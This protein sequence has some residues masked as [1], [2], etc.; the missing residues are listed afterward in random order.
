M[1]VGATRLIPLVG[2]KIEGREPIS[3]R[4][5]ASEQRLLHRANAIGRFIRTFFLPLDGAKK[6]SSR[7]LTSAQC[8]WETSKPDLDY[9]KKKEIQN[10]FYRYEQSIVIRCGN[11]KEIKMKCLIIETKGCP[12]TGALNHLIVQANTSTLDNNMP[13]IYPYLDSYMKEKEENPEL[14]H[15][16]FVV[17]SH[18]DNTICLGAGKKEKKYLPGDINEWGFLFKKTIESLAEKYGRF[19]LIAAHSVGNMPVIAH[20]KHI[21]NEEFDRLFPDALFLSHG[22]SSLYEASKNVPHGLKWYPWGW[23]FFLIG[24]I[25]YLV[26]KWVRWNISLDQTLVERLKELSQDKNI[27]EKL[28]KTNIIVSAVKHDHLFPGKATLF[29]SDLLEDCK[30]KVNLYGVQFDIPTT[31]TPKNGQ[32]TYPLDRLQKKDIYREIPPTDDTIRLRDG[33]HL[34]DAVMRS[35]HFPVVEQIR[36]SLKNRVKPL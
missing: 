11:G 6:P 19:Q 3:C 27:A 22:L 10:A 4:L 13:A 5:N 35:A 8:F 18:Y 34:V 20:L 16:R 9:P 28:K 29:G 31:R 7:D 12:E 23:C 30:D 15:G 2:H 32:H 17:F 1:S 14:P 25:L 24:A 21:K 26:A 36:T 33:E